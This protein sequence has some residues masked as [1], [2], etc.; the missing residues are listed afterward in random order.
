[1]SRDWNE[2]KCEGGS[3]NNNEWTRAPGY[4]NSSRYK[5]NRRELKQKIE[6]KSHTVL[7][8]SREGALPKGA[9]VRVRRSLSSFPLGLEGVLGS[10]RGTPS[11]DV[12]HVPCS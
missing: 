11:R 2:C 7:G 9:R 3:G 1:M 12:L 10:L 6:G 8:S 4:L 5:I